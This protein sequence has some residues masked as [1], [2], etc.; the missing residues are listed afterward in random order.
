MLVGFVNPLI[1]FK[2]FCNVHSDDTLPPSTSLINSK[3]VTEYVDLS[4]SSLNLSIAVVYSAVDIS[5]SPYKLLYCRSSS[6]FISSSDKT[7]SASSNILL[8]LA[9]KSNSTLSASFS[10]RS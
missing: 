7:L 2:P 6:A 9:D 3:A 1:I 10:L 4:R 8:N 5:L